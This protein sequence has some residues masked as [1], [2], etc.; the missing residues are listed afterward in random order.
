MPTLEW[1][2]KGEGVAGEEEQNVIAVSEHLREEGGLGLEK[3]GL[4]DNKYRFCQCKNCLIWRLRE[5][6]KEKLFRRVCSGI[7]RQKGN[8]R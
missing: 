6:D 5:Q 4:H 8:A 1:L 3:K 7:L 2:G